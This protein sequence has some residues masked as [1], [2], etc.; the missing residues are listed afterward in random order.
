MLNLYYKPSCPY[1]QR[2][3]AANEEIKAPLE[4][5]DITADPNFREELI[6]KGGKGQVP[7]LEDT[8]HGVAMYESAD[9]I[10][11]LAENYGTGAIPNIPQ[12]GNVC[13]ID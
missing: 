2:V 9:I 11:Y 13:P 4:L 12:T 7:Y 8:D 6:A 10:D 1:C 5:I 3:L